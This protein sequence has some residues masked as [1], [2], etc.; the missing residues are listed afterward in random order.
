MNFEKEKT[1]IRH[2]YSRFG[3]G[4]NSE[5]WVK[6][7]QGFSLEEHVSKMLQRKN[8][9]GKEI[10]FDESTFLSFLQIKRLPKKQRVEQK[11][12]KKQNRI[13]LNIWWLE[14]MAGNSEK[15][16]AEKMTLFWHGHFACRIK[17][18]NFS[19]RYLNTIRK[20]A[21]GNFRSLVKEIAKEPAMLYFLNGTKNRKSK[22][23]E[24]FARELLELFTIGIGN[25]SEKDIQEAARAFTGWSIDKQKN[26]TAKFKL[27]QHD[28]GVKFFFDKKGNLNG[29]DIID[30]ILD[31]RETAR[32]IA[33]KIFRYF[34]NKKE[35]SEIID[36]LAKVFYDND[37]EILPLIEEIIKSDWFYDSKNLGN[38]IKSP[39]ELIIGLM[40]HINLEFT[41]P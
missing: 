7:K 39:I 10:D 36:R 13:D 27:K 30:L 2:L 6:A 38:K 37:Y 31:K 23:N 26:Y 25:Y 33:A 28:N 18:P 40:K 20:N 19:Y 5:E 34:V 32:F 11:K 35:D 16:L 9:A 8:I 3:F 14:Q 24:N 4:L 15:C 1:R 29:E 17:K 21:L 22:P 12:Q 41:N